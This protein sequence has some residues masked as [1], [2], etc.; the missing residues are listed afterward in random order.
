MTLSLVPIFPVAASAVADLPQNTPNAVPP[1]NP[2]TILIQSGGD[3]VG[4]A[5]HKLPFLRALRASFPNSR[6][7]YLARR[8]P[9]AFAGSLR[10]LAEPYLDEIH[11][12]PGS[13]WRLAKLGWRV[14]PDL[15]LDTQR[16]VHFG[17]SLRLMVPF[18][19]WVSP[20]AKFRW[21]AAKPADGSGRLPSR[22]HVY[23]LLDLVQLA[24]GAEDRAPLSY[25]CTLPPEVVAQA[26]AL[27]P[28]AEAG[29]GTPIIGLAPGAGA[30]RK[31][32]PLDRYLE[33]AQ[34]MQERGYRVAWILGPN[35]GDWLA[36]VRAAQSGQPGA[37]FPLQDAVER[38]WSPSPLLTIA[39]AQ[40]FAVGVANDSGVGHMLAVANC[41]LISLFGPTDPGKFSPITERLSIVRFDPA[42][43]AL[44]LPSIV[45]AV[46]GWLTS[47]AQNTF[48]QS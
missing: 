35:E 32:W 43:P 42:D 12:P 17:L 3:L 20:I 31:C 16:V 7:V 15:V 21:S 11:N 18:G 14:R 34:A 33:L 29:Q 40:R 24:S 41:P 36:E 37:L 23:W 25:G 47:P 39:L 44:A 19:R 1:T 45:T 28:D 10:P 8:T 4:D 38:G 30:R 48:A 9:T 13:W 26:A 27:L 6:L 46:E 2:H 22:H 5:L